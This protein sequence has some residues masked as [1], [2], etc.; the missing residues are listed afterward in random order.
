MMLLRVCGKIDECAEV[1][2]H[3]CTCVCVCVCV[4]GELFVC[5]CL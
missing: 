2:V 3:V 4:A 5:V 1:C